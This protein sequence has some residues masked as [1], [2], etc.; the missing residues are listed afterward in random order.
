[1]LFFFY[2][3]TFSLDLAGFSRPGPKSGH[4]FKLLAAELSL[5]NLIA[6]CCSNKNP[7]DKKIKGKYIVSFLLRYPNQ[8]QKQ[9][10]KDIKLDQR[11]RKKLEVV[12]ILLEPSI[13]GLL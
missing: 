6:N 10:V 5:Q 7:W 8:A 9:T 12:K 2:L 4:K 3:S 13:S 1:M 11:R